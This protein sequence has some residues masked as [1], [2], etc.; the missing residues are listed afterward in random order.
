M[1]PGFGPGLD[2]NLVPR[3]IP[4]I[5]PAKIIDLVE[6]KSKDIELSYKFKKKV[7]NHPSRLEIE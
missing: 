3:M 4:L 6:S 1:G 2:N 7:M 5:H